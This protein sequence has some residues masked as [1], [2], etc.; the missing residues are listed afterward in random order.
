VAAGQP[1]RPPHTQ[2][3][4]Q[5]GCLAASQQLQA[6]LPQ[7]PGSPAAA[8]AACT[9]Q[10]L[11]GAAAQQ[12]PGGLLGGGGAAAGSTVVVATGGTVT[13]A[14]A[15]LQ[16]L[17]G[18][19][20]GLVH[21]SRVALRQLEGLAAELASEEGQQRWV[22]R[23]RALRAYCPPASQPPLQEPSP[24]CPPPPQGTRELWLA[25]GEPRRLAGRRLLRAAGGHAAAGRGRG[26]GVGG[27]P[28][29]RAAAQRAG[30]GGGGGGGRWMV[31]AAGEGLR[32]A[33]EL[34]C[35]SCAACLFRPRGELKC[36][37]WGTRP[38][39]PSGHPVC[40]TRRASSTPAGATI[41]HPVP[42]HRAPGRRG[43]GLIRTQPAI[44][45]RSGHAVRGLGAA[46]RQG[47]LAP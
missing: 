19:D 18:Y 10:L 27:G 22:R 12:L 29:G 34:G 38:R 30:G 11:Q 21:W 9:E 7:H 47:P 23:R 8:A 3:S 26:A 25:V 42:N 43:G 24:S 17:P 15:V 33:W 39:P 16:R 31:R 6:L 40:R 41:R 28:A 13:T 32:G 35:T 36:A 2:L 14:S 5:L 37:E 20:P 46:S 45:L 44:P 1:G 4:L